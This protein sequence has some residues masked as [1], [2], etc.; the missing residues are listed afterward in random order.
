MKLPAPFHTARTTTP[1]GDLLLA[2][3]PAGL[4]G[5]WFIRGQRDTPAP[6][7]WGHGAPAYPV[8]AEAARWMDEYFVGRRNRFGLPLDL[9]AGT[10]FQQD[11]W[12]A[13]LEI[14]FGACM[15]YSEL[16][17]RI[18]RPTAVRAVGAAVGAN[19]LIIIAPCHRVLGVGGALTGFG[20][21]LERKVALLRL[22]GWRIDGADAR[23]PDATL[24]RLR[25]W[26]EGHR[27]APGLF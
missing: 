24:R 13:L 7:T 19:P 10:S 2:A 16:A 26:R 4:A 6:D 3:T 23:T 25:P 18:G 15:S 12:R 8:L 14:D 1:L 5:A 17:A 27:Q 11:V 22:E 9:S 21:G 20:G